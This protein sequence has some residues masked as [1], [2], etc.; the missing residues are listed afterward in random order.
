MK[1]WLGAAGIESGPVFRPVVGATVKPERLSDKAVNRIVKKVAAAIGLDP[2]RFG[3]HSLRV[4]FVTIAG[5]SAS[6]ASLMRHTTHRTVLQL[7]KYLRPVTL[8]S[9]NAAEHLGL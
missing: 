8:F 6:E 9:D 7:R 2:S 3:G 4:S 5:A 1:D